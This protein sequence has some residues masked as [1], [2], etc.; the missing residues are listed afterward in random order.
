ME[1]S[2][3]ILHVFKHSVKQPKDNDEQNWENTDIHQKD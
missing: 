3:S 2:Q 1:H